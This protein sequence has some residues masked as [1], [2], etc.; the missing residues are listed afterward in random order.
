MLIYIF[1]QP[2]KIKEQEFKDI[3]L[4]TMDNFIMYELQSTGL[5]TNM[6]GTN[7]LR[8]TDRYIVENVNFTDN[9]KEFIS[10]MQ[11]NKGVYKNSTVNLTGEVVYTR[12]DGLTFESDTLKYNTQSAIAQ[13][14]DDYL[15]YKGD[16]SMLGASFIYDSLNN[17]MKSKK[18]IVKYQLK[19]SKI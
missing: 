9:S 14:Q 18:V 19:E 17:I 6:S 3:P 11:A 7:A 5:Q 13:T 2:L 10:N 4:L 12:E 1:F 15:A 8:Y 16:N